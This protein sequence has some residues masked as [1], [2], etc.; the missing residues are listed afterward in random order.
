MAAANEACTLAVE[1]QLAKTVVEFTELKTDSGSCSTH[2]LPVAS[3]ATTLTE[4]RNLV[5]TG[6]IDME[7]PSTRPGS[8]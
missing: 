8:K 5:E 3:P 7:T 4:K 2:I 1:A 6:S